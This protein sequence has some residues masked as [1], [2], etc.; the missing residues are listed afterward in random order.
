V[1]VV[2]R[3]QAALDA[4][5]LAAFLT[6]QPSRTSAALSMAEPA[7][8]QALCASLAKLATA[9]SNSGQDLSRSF[10]RHI[11]TTS[12]CTTVVQVDPRVEYQ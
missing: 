2:A 1:P 12:T 10:I 8:S 5:G 9:P 6:L 4:S 11:I 7:L 3:V